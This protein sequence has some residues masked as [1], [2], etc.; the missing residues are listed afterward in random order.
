MEKGSDIKITNRI[1]SAIIIFLRGL[2]QIMLQKNATTGLLF[3]VAIFIGSF[4]MGIAASLAVLC[5]TL[6]A[7]LLKYNRTEIEDGLYGFSAALVGIALIFYFKPVFVVWLFIIIGSIAAAM[8]QHFFI[9]KKIPAFTLP[10]VL[11]T[12]VIMFLI[13]NLLTVPLSDFLSASYSGN[14]NFAFVLKGF[15]Q[16]IFQKG[17]LTG[18]ILFIGVFINS[19]VAA[20][21]AL[22]GSLFSAVFSD[23]FSAPADAVGIGL[24]SYNAVL[25]AILFADT[26]K[27]SGIWFFIAI[28]LTAIISSLMFK[29]KII[30]LTFPFVCASVISLFLKSQIDKILHNH[31]AN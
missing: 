16:V 11:V 19:P 4:S 20:L 31:P 13:K 8:L 23:W 27:E 2:G 14:Q 18:V 25:S 5:G 29:F 26:K 9:T 3:L 1:P 12:W 30:Q 15:S 6:T 17:F 21:Y 24:Y 28:F 22:A 7:I 10:F